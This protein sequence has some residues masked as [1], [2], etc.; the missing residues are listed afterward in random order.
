V[1]NHLY[2]FTM[3]V[4]RGDGCDMPE[5]M[6]GAL[7][8]TYVGASDYQAA[9]KKGVAAIRGMHYVFEGI[10]GRVRELPVQRWEEYLAQV[11]PEFTSHFPSKEQLPPLVENGEVFFGPFGGFK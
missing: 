11:W 9:V 4:K 1:P 8:P 5:G 7:V 3:K 10:Q 2:E 6:E